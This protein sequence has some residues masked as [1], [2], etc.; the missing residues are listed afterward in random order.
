MLHSMSLT[1]LR[2]ALTPGKC[3]IEG[4]NF[5][6]AYGSF[7]SNMAEIIK[8]LYMGDFKEIDQR[9]AEY[10]SIGYDTLDAFY[11]NLEENSTSS[12]LLTNCSAY[13]E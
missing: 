10:N 4:Q 11:N 8:P 13:L 2:P 5:T 12:E 6:S 7:V 9:K 1:E 3:V